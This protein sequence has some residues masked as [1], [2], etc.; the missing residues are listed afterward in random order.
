MAWSDSG[1]LH[2]VTDSAEIQLQEPQLLTS[3][4]YTKVTSHTGCPTWSANIMDSARHAVFF[5]WKTFCR[6]VEY[7]FKSWECSAAGTNSR[8][9][10]G[11]N[12]ELGH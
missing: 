11:D 8:G 6:Q 2:T 7:C 12:S 5:A 9:C 3:I 10:A 1:P 4:W